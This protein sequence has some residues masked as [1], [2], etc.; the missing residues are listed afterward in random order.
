MLDLN[1]IVVFARVVETGSFTAAARLLAMPK[2][3]VSRRVAALER[4]VG[5]R[6]LQRTTRSL[7]V[8]DAGRLY[9]E[10]SSQALRTIE[11]ANLRLAEARAEPSGTI[12]ISAP[13]GF[14]GHFLTAAVVD[15]LAIYP[16]TK[17]E[18]R[19]TD[20]KLNLVEDGIDLA[21]RTGILQD[22]TLIARKL[23]STHRLLCA[24]P[25]YLARRGVPE[26]LADLAHHQCVIAGPSTS[27]THWVLD[28]PHGQETVT[29]VGR[30]AANEMQA[31]V[32]ATLAGFGIAQLPH[33]I[34]E[35]LINGGRLSRVL[36]DYTTPVGGLHVLYPS[37][38]HLSPLV[39]A[40]IELAS[41]RISSRA[42]TAADQQ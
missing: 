30:F 10:Q 16:K 3:T 24:S 37:S 17:V 22:S 9:Y 35:P 40:F 41:D 5:V 33:S 25:D 36:R 4:E 15:F 20:D 18:L 2:T 28:G 13:V 38:R 19:L 42:S 1:D 11:E 32:A 31:V 39:K 26:R 34:A 8:T 21:F 27:G 6:L 23:G 29:V 12:R 14:G 7:N